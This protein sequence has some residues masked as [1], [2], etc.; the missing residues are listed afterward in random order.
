MTTKYM[1]SAA[2]YTLTNQSFYSCGMPRDDALHILRDVETGDIPWTGA[3]TGL[4]ILGL[5]VW[6]Q[7][8]V[9]F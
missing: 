3:L 9:R 2:N 7:D 1:N 5:Y 6:C 4:T 8:Q